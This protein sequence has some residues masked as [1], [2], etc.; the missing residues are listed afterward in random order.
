MGT[1]PPTL[2]LPTSS[3]RDYAGQAGGQE[4]GK[5]RTSNIQH[6]TLNIEVAPTYIFSTLILASTATGVVPAGPTIKGLMS[7][8]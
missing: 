7:I 1:V 2:K 5:R 8:S 6:R 3:A 4:A